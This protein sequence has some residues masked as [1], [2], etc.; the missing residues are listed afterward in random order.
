MYIGSLRMQC[1]E[2][3][4]NTEMHTRTCVPV[5]LLLAWR[6][7]GVGCVSSLLFGKFPSRRV[8]AAARANNRRLGIFVPNV[9][10]I[11]FWRERGVTFFLMSSDHSFIKQGANKLVA[12]ARGS[13]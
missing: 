8:C 11:P 2:L 5:S 9:D 6:E 1:Y 7:H 12:D 4:T 10:S 3:R 13:F